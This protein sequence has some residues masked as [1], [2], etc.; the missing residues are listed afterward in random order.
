MRCYCFRSTFEG[1]LMLMLLRVF[2]FQATLL[3]NWNFFLVFLTCKSFHRS[4]IYPRYFHVLA[5][6]NSFLSFSTP[7]TASCMISGVSILWE[8]SLVV[9]W[10]HFIRTFCHIYDSDGSRNIP[11]KI[12]LFYIILFNILSY[13]QWLLLHF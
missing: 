2:H 9:F 5:F 7:F 1:L 8:T 4:E 11:S 12:H 10:F 3:C 6:V 13:K